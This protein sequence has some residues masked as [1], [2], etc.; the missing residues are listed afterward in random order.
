M[1][2]IDYSLCEKCGA[3]AEIYPLFFVM[4][5]DLPWF[6]NHD[7]FN[8]KEHGDIPKCCPFRAIVIE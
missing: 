2:Y 5:D 1:L 8:P 6:I 7:K 4:K 3:C